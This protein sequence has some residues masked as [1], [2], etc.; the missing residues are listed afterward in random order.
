VELGAFA[1]IQRVGVLTATDALGLETDFR[2]DVS[3]GHDGTIATV[4]VTYERSI[5][6]TLYAGARVG[7]RYQNADYA[8]AYYGVSYSESA[9]SGLPSFQAQSGWH[10]M[11]A[12][13]SASHRLKPALSVEARAQYDRLI[14]SLRDSPVARG[15]GND[16]QWR[17][18]L[19]LGYRF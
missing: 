11:T 4:S 15:P 5:G 13:L 17:F 18:G 10:G 2:A 19:A 8:N 3:S 16:E 14:G 1:H 12:A 9:V 7:I 6:R